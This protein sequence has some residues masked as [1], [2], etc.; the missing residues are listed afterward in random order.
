MDHPLIIAALMLAG[1][2]VAGLAV[3]A[4]A[5]T[6]KATRVFGISALSIKIVLALAFAV[7]IFHVRTVPASVYDEFGEYL[8]FFSLVIVGIPMI[9][10]AIA[11]ELAAWPR[12][13][14]RTREARPKTARD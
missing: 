1:V 5:T 12:M 3:D 13:S 9:G 7:Q 8:T 6:S 10:I 2:S 11:C 14:R 4:R